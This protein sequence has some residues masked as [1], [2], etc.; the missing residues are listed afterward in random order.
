MPVTLDNLREQR[1]SFLREHEQAVEN[2]HRTAGALQFC[3]HLIQVL[4]QEQAEKP[5]TAG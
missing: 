5:E 3:E 2:V 1:A 4:V